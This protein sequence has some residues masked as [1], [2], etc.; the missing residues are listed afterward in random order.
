MRTW[1]DGNGEG[2]GHS[3]ALLRA[4]TCLAAWQINVGFFII[5][6]KEGLSRAPCYQTA[7]FRRVNASSSTEPLWLLWLE[8]IYAGNHM[9][10][11]L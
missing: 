4:G 8:R 11:H 10:F 5:D 9:H 6:S 1:W 3:Q 2:K 7:H